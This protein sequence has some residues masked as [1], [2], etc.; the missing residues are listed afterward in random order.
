LLKKGIAQN[1]QN[2]QKTDTE[3]VAQ[4]RISSVLFRVVLRSE[5][6]GCSPSPGRTE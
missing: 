2:A 1:A 3:R 6:T 5:K 4:G